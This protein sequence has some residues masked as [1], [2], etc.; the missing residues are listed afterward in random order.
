MLLR[1]GGRSN[2]DQEE[3][4]GAG[5]SF[6]IQPVDDSSGVHGKDVPM[7]TQSPDM[8]NVTVPSVVFSK[9]HNKE[10]KKARA[11]KKIQDRAL[12]AATQMLSSYPGEWSWV[13]RI[14]T[15]VHSQHPAELI[16]TGS[17]DILCSA[18]PTHWR[19]N[20]SLPVVFKVVSLSG[21]VEDGTLVT[22]S[23]GNDENY[24]AE[25][26][27]NQSSMKDGVAK[28]TDLRFVGRSGRGKSF[29]LIIT[30]HSSPVQ[31]TSSF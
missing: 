8:V 10:E 16:R 4:T 1:S 24:G 29:N 12:Q 6:L 19:S 18:L 7:V 27:N 14:L 26:R 11:Q 20:K 23:A 22:L 28:F 5:G 21:V 3:T 25:L 15:M 2:Q 17:P 9:A 30:I 31:V 13:E